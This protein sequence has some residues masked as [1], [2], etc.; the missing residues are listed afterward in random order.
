MNSTHRTM[1]AIALRSSF[2]SITAPGRSRSS[3]AGDSARAAGARGRGRAARH[4]ARSPRAHTW[5]RSDES[6]TPRARTVPKRSGNRGPRSGPDGSFRNLRFARDRSERTGGGEHALDI[7]GEILVGGRE[8][9]PVGDQ[10]EPVAG[11]RDARPADP[12]DLAQ[13]PPGAIALDRAAH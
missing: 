1:A 10:H 8:R 6:D 7:V 5:S 13:P 12:Q 2:W 3:R 9:A 4:G 11:V